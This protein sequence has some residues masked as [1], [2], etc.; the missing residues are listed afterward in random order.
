[1]QLSFE[2][3]HQK[4]HQ[5]LLIAIA[6]TLAFPIKYNSWAIALCTLNWIVS[7]NW[8]NK[9]KNCYKDR[10]SILL[11]LLFLFHVLGTLL[12]NNTHEALAILERRSSLILLPLLIIGNKNLTN[13]IIQKVSFSFVIGIVISLIYCIFRAYI[14]YQ[15]RPVIAEFFYHD[16][17]SAVNMNAIYMAAYCILGLHIVIHYSNSINTYLAISLSCILLVGC[18]MLNSKMMFVVLAIGITYKLLSDKINLKSVMT[19]I[20]IF[21]VLGLM[22]MLIPETRKRVS[23]EL[24]SNFEVLHQD[25]FRY[26]T[27]FTGTSLRLLIWK[28][29]FAIQNR[30]K[31][32]LTGVGIGDFQDQLN[33]QY[34]TVGMYTGNPALHDKGY[35]EYGPHN[36]YIEVL[37][38]LGIFALLVL[39]YIFFTLIKESIALNQYLLVQLMLLILFFCFTESVLSTNKGIIF[40]VFFVVL[41]RQSIKIN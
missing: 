20:V 12:S 35:L 34:S 39:V 25:Q 24:T 14:R 3:I 18:I 37:F 21:V 30:E 7:G 6:F 1:M 5:W 2:H 31:A 36:E 28:Y 27:H 8:I 9:I 17:S 23:Y 13:A 33:S 19:S 4:I 11:L 26:D 38:S 15:S 16:L 32:W 40:F 41:Y 10:I 29:C 22:I